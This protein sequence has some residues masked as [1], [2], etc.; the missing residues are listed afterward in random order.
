M[1]P[2]LGATLSPVMSITPLNI[3]LQADALVN[4]V[5]MPSMRVKDSAIYS[6]FV[7]EGGDELEMV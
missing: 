5:P 6:A 4:V 7:Q 2:I 1:T 3:I